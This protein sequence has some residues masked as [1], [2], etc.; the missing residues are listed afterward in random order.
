M[1]HTPPGLPRGAGF[2][3]APIPWGSGDPCLAYRSALAMRTTTSSICRTDPMRNGRAPTTGPC[4][5]A[6]MAA[7]GDLMCADTPSRS[8]SWRISHCWAAGP[9]ASSACR[10]TSTGPVRPRTTST[11]RPDRRP[12][13]RGSDRGHQTDRSPRI[14]RPGDVPSAMAHALAATRS[15]PGWEER[16]HELRQAQTA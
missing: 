13:P 2:F 1:S 5:P 6:T 3:L 7:G 11:P 16:F 14:P 4:S 9:Q 10:R 15:A 8:L 12:L